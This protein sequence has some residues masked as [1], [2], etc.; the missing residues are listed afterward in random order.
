MMRTRIPRKNL[1][2]RPLRGWFSLGCAAHGNKLL[3]FDGVAAASVFSGR[4]LGMTANK[5][6]VCVAF[7]ALSCGLISAADEPAAYWPGWRGKDRDAVSKDKGLLQE[8]PKGGP[9]LLW[10]FEAAGFGY[11]TP[12]IVGKEMFIL[13][14]D[15]DGEFIKKL[16]T[17]GKELGKAR[18]DGTKSDYMDG[19]GV[20]PRSTPSIDGDLVFTLSS[21]GRLVC[22]D[23]STLSE[24]WSKSLV[25]D[26][27]GK[28]PGWGY[29]ESPLVDG[30]NVVVTP[31]GSNCVVA[32][33]KSSGG[34]IWKSTGINDGAHYSSLVPLTV[35]G[36]KMY[37]NQASKHL[38]GI[39]ASTGKLAW[40]FGEIQRK[41]AVIPTPIISGNRVYATADY[42][43]GCE[44]VD[45]VKS[46]DSFEAKKVFVNKNMENH[47]G[48]VIL[49]N[50]YIYGYSGNNEP[51]ARRKTPETWV[52]QKLSDG[53]VASSV[54]AR[55]IGK[56]S[57]AYAD[58]LFYL[59]E[60]KI[61]G[62][63]IL[64]NASPSAWKEISR[65]K[66][67]KNSELKRG[68]RNG[69][70]VWVHPIIVDGKL[71]LRDLDLLFCYDVKK[72]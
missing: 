39:D 21:M 36:V 4:G 41:T 71:Y 65:F 25:E 58:G 1:G 60:Q 10:T 33:N 32:L 34:V 57:I 3:F 16:S 9:K 70:L 62:S 61:G 28:T 48:G 52:C 45:I 40:K 7:A 19:W 56:G 18:I 46:G 68:S 8:W 12:A 23:R 26:F 11:G 72:Q 24:K 6:A 17:D 22:F 30:D 51:N 64:M 14:K 55:N 44:C 38:F 20:G 67:P 27:G 35:D 63:C 13:G 54:E 50:G 37:V 53:S 15:D 69:G 31:G 66:L 59:Y 29:A 2:K 47:H 43:A 5:L 42:Q 49:V